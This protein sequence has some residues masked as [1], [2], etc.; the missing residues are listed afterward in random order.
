[1]AAPDDGPADAVGSCCGHSVQTELVALD[2]LHH[3]TR[4]VVAIGRQQPHAY[5]TERDQSYAFGLK[6]GQTL[7][8]HE[9]GTDPNV[10]VQPVLDD[11]A[12]C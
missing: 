3:Q 12:F 5:R 1:M 2:V 11:L 4:L 8:T 10:E 6:Y 9:P 7:F